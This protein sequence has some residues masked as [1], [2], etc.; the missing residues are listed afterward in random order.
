ME[1]GLLWVA[2]KSYVN[3]KARYFRYPHMMNGVAFLMGSGKIK[4]ASLM[5]LAFFLHAFIYFYRRQRLTLKSNK[6]VGLFRLSANDA[7][8]VL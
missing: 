7:D 1:S 2:L 8:T 4:Q 6:I 3:G 5:A